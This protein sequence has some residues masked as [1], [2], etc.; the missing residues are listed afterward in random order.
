MAHALIYLVFGLV[1]AAW[2][3]FEF[4]KDFSLKTHYRWLVGAV[5]FGLLGAVLS[6][7]VGANAGNFLLHSVG[8]GMASTCL[9]LYL[10]R[11]FKFKPN[12]RLELA[13]L[14]LFTCALGVLNELGEFFIEETFSV[15]MSIDSQDTWRDFVANTSGAFLLWGVLRISWLSKPNS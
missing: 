10:A 7:I 6:E 3:R 15:I 1:S 14:F 8:G 12:W 2:L 11:P 5:G 13:S 9:Y 4:R